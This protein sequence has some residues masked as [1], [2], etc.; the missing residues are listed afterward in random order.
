MQN[1]SPWSVCRQHRRILCVAYPLLVS[2][3]PPFITS[4]CSLKVPKQLLAVSGSPAYKV[5]TY[6]SCLATLSSHALRFV[7]A[8]FNDTLAPC[9]SCTC[10]CPSVLAPLDLTLSAGGTC[11]ASAAADWDP[12]AALL[13]GD[14]LAGLE[15]PTGLDLSNDSTAKVVSHERS[16]MLHPAAQVL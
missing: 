8:F 5:R 9:L 1:P 7:A 10:R 11:S 16:C 15:P 13:L 2:G 12:A 6:P 3:Q 4:G 14:T